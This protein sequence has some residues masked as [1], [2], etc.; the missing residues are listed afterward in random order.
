LLS[1][2]ALAAYARQRD[3]SALIEVSRARFAFLVRI[4][5]LSYRREPE[6]RSLFQRL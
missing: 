2:P 4:P 3:S 5:I 1:T 6:R